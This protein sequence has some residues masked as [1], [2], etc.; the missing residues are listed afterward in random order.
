[1]QRCHRASVYASSPLHA[2]SQA[3]V[4]S[5]AGKQAGVDMPA[6]AASVQ[7]TGG[8]H[9]GVVE[10]LQPGLLVPVCMHAPL[11]IVCAVLCLQSQLLRAA[12]HRDSM[13]RVH[14]CIAT[15]C[16]LF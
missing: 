15:V 4:F 5:Q 11:P 13:A 7:G 14:C 9:R 10:P 16:A 8:V 6:L 3:G 12:Q 1:M 2:C